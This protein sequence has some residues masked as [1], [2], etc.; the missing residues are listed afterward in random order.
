MTERARPVAYGGRLTVAPRWPGQ[1]AAVALAAAVAVVLVPIPAVAGVG[2]EALILRCGKPTLNKVA[3]TFDDGPTRRFTPR[4]LQ[5]LEREKVKATFFVL[6]EMARREPDLVK[7]IHQAGH[8]LAAH[9][10]S[11]PKRGSL[12][13]WREEMRRTDE[14]VRAAGQ[15]LAPYFRPPH[16]KITAAVRQAAS[17]RGY[18]IVLY[19]LLSSDW[20]RPGAE[21]LVRQVVRVLA[22]GGVVVLHDGGGERSQTVAALPEIIRG[23]RQKG[24]EPVRLDELL[25][26]KPGLETCARSR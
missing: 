13:E 1:G 20:T 16:G 24:L 10:Y 23:L 21:A 2:D 17:E 9:S 15:E 14:A 6:G 3:L 12:A 26:P 5:I 8:L 11:H 4:V 25:G 18:A 19:T 7:R 22:P